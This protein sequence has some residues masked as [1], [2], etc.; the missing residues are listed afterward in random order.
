V[1]ANVGRGHSLTPRRSRRTASAQ[2]RR[3]G[4]AWTRA[5]VTSRRV[6]FGPGL[7]NVPLFDCT[8]P[9]TLH[10]NFKIDR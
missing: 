5:R 3:S 1:V 2:W 10:V 6:R 7:S 8:M 4:D 9:Q